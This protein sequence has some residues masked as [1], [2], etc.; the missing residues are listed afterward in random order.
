MV[1]QAPRHA[2]VDG[3]ASLVIYRNSLSSGSK[4]GD[5]SPIPG[6][7]SSVDIWDHRDRGSRPECRRPNDATATSCGSA[8]PLGPAILPINGIGVAAERPV[9]TRLARSGDLSSAGQ[10]A[11]LA[12]AFWRRRRDFHVVSKFRPPFSTLSLRPAHSA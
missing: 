2:G 12:A 3:E 6:K 5:C 7:A 11:S 4:L 1:G 8:A 10:Q 9:G